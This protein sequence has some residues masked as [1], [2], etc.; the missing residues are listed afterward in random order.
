MSKRANLAHNSVG[1]VQSKYI[2]IL[3]PYHWSPRSTD[4]CPAPHKTFMLLFVYVE[5][6][7][8]KPH[9]VSAL[10]LFKCLLT[11][12][13]FRLHFYFLPREMG[14]FSIL[15]GI[16]Q[17]LPRPK[18]QK[19][20]KWLHSFITNKTT[21]SKGKLSAKSKSYAD[22]WVGWRILFWFCVSFSLWD[23]GELNPQKCCGGVRMKEPTKSTGWAQLLKT[24]LNKCC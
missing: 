15:N 4:L 5:P 21:L 22:L 24:N 16:S 2:N 3:Y 1:T 8:I 23:L 17:I 20:A 13:I 6:A 11:N 12:A 10:D 14:I 9:S 18:L 19:S 7:E